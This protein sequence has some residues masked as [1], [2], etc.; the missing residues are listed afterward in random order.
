[1]SV[2]FYSESFK[3]LNDK[4]TEEQILF[5]FSQVCTEGRLILVFTFDDL[6]RI[7]T[8]HFTI[9]HY[10]ELIPRSVLAVNVS[11][12]SCESKNP[13]QYFSHKMICNLDDLLHWPEFAA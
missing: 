12:F 7:K 3:K 10:S 4:Q 11:Y 8:W 13:P 5:L 6:M 2:L 9:T 1:M